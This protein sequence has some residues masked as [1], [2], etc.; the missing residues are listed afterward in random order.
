[1]LWD[2]Q[3]EDDLQGLRRSYLRGAA[4]A[5]LVA[6][7]TRPDTVERAVELG[8]VVR[9]VAG[10]VPLLLLINK[11]DLDAEWAIDSQREA[12]L[13]EGWT[14]LRTSAKTGAGVEEA[15][16]Q[17]SELLLGAADDPPP[18]GH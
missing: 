5:F 13:S 14:V 11:A 8:Q 10:D 17:L 2:L 4:G 18:S 1:M 12:A 6:D 9:E 7:G 15:F 16:Q 3:G